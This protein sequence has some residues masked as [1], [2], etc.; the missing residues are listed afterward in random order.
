MSQLGIGRF[1]HRATEDTEPE[2]KNASCKTGTAECKIKELS[3]TIVNLHFPPV[4]L[5]VLSDSVVSFMGI[6][7][8]LWVFA[9]DP[10]VPKLLRVPFANRRSDQMSN[11]PTLRVHYLPQFVGEHEL[12]GGTVIVIDLLRAST[13]VAAALAAG[14]REVQ[15]FTEV[16]FALA[17]A[18]GQN[19]AEILLGGERGGEVIDGFDLG[20]SPSEYTASVVFGR[21]VLFTTTNGTWALEHARLAKS[22]I[23]GCLW[24]LSA[25][26]D[27]V[28]NATDLHIL[29]AGTGGKVS[30]EDL[31][32]A[33][34]YVDRLTSDEQPWQL[35]EP[36]EAVCR[37]WEELVTTAAALG[38]STS[39][40]VAIELRETLGGK[41][42]IAIG[43]DDDLDTCAAIDRVD[44]V[45][46]MDRERGVL[47]PMV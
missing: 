20:N 13:T 33:G 7:L 39:E 21:R 28:S 30:R 22:T 19:R 15:P 46:I 42:L 26:S 43:H 47:V 12:A 17:A 11:S 44:V 8:V 14:A 4:S 6:E 40:Q 37:E 36:A 29:C 9:T 41:N 35:S 32:A 1:Y 23:V 45:P 24:N 34:A 38:R 16:A 27:A 25:V 31:L 2:Q 10:F 5:R 3:S 18:D